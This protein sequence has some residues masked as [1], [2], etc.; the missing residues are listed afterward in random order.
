MRL[1]L[2]RRIRRQG[3]QRSERGERGREGMTERSKDER[4]KVVNR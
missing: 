4:G 3:G 1:E 2:P